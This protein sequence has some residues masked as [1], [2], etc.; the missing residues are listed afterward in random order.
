MVKIVLNDE[1]KRAI[2]DQY[3]KFLLLLQW[4]RLSVEKVIK[5]TINP[6]KAE[7]QYEIL[8]HFG[9][10][11]GKKV[12]EIGTGLG[13]NFISWSIEHNIDGY[14]IESDSEG[15]ESSFKLSRIILELN[16]LNPD[17]IINATGESIPFENNSFDAVYSTNVLEHTTDP[18]KVLEEALR[19]LKP[20]GLMQFVYPNYH[21]FFDG[22]Y[23]VF[24]PPVFFK[25]FF[26]WYIKYICGRD[27]SFAKT[28]RTELNLFWTKQ[29][30]KRLR[31]K[32]NFEVLSMGKELFYERMSYLN[33]EAWAGLVIVKRTVEIL[34]SLKLNKIFAKFFIFF[35]C[36]DPVILTIK[37]LN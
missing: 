29:A 9:E 6:L 23:A 2:E 33:F 34:K 26:P 1:L 27:N 37:K 32:Y 10:I 12:L 5:D 17:R 31:L 14:G 11:K 16:G 22:H 25:S 36:Y 35:N 28:L 4:K 13:I 30:V 7:K 15:F 3:N 18:Y 21:S 20:G 8:N 19:V 24:H